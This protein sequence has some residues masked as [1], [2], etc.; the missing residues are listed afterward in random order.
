VTK[1]VKVYHAPVGEADAKAI[2]AYLA[3]TY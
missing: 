3:A 2:A 1:M